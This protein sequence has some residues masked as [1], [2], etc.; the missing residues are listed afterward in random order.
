MHKS[1]PCTHTHS[2]Y[3]HVYT[4]VYTLV[5]VVHADV[6]VC[7][8]EQ[9]RVDSTVAI[10][11]V[12]EEAIDGISYTRLIEEAIVWVHLRLDVR[13]LCPQQV[14]LGED[15]RGVVDRGSTAAAPGFDGGKPR[16]LM[17]RLRR[18]EQ[19]IVYVH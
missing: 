9:Q 17:S 11:R 1:Y 3:A 15:G 8:P 7:W 14:W 6:R 12:V 10:H 2:A 5:A 13:G 19:L 18:N 4:H 16:T